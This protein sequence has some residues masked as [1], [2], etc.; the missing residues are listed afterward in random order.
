MPTALLCPGQGAQHVGM[1]RDFRDKFGVAARIYDQADKALGFALSKICFEGPEEQLNKTDVAQLGIFVTSVAIFETLLELGKAAAPDFAAGL[2]LGEYSALHIAGVF[3]FEDGLKI[4]RARGQLMQAAAEAGP[5]TMLALLGADEPAANA[6]CAEAAQGEILV[7]ANF[8]TPG[9]IVLSGAIGACAR[10]AKVA[11]AKGFKSVPLKVAGAFH[12][13][14]MQAAADQMAEVLAPIRFNPARM[15]VISNVTA[16]PHGEGDS[17]K[18]LL[19]QQIIAPVRWY[20]SIETLRAKGVDKWIEVGPGRSLTGMM[21]KIDRKAPIENCS[22]TE[23][24]A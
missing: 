21:K 4:V 24:L 5:S 20:Q 12:S 10:A 11:E 16:A 8:N 3:S 22:T 15:P 17:I 1:G 19:V 14:F 23:G 13:P 9:Q 2:S 7:P 18:R 6:I